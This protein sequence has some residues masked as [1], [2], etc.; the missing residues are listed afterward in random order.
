M[1]ASKNLGCF[2]VAQLF[3]VVMLDRIQLYQQ[4]STVNDSHHPNQEVGHHPKK[5][6][7]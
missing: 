4:Y 6:Q 7:N 3:K 1:K 5:E 2:Q